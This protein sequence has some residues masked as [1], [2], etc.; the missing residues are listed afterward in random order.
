MGPGE[1]CDDGNDGRVDESKKA[2][3]DEFIGNT[4]THGLPRIISN[5]Y[6]ILIRVFWSLV[7]LT[8]FAVLCFQGTSLVID[9]FKRPLST[10]LTI[11]TQSKLDFPA[12][13]ICNLNM[14][15]KSMLWG[16][17]VLK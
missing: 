15:R 1:P 14:M 13:T 4:T 7:T 11:V 6:S 2:I 16:K 3:L 17:L 9:Y 10:K 8:F 5:Q 12:V